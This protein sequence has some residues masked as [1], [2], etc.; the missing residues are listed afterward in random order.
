M[1][2][3]L[4]N[5]KTPSFT[6]NSPKELGNCSLNLWV[7]HQGIKLHG[8]VNSPYNYSVIINQVLH[9]HQLTW[10]GDLNKILIALFYQNF[11]PNFFS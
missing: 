1:A 11:N 9:I 3:E 10:L 2:V 4:T 5:I 7:V 6:S 8:L